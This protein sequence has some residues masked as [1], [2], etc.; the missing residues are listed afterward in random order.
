M[1]TEAS[2]LAKSFVAFAALF[3]LLLPDMSKVYA[4]ASSLPWD[5][6][7]THLIGDVSVSGGTFS[8]DTS[9]AELTGSV[10]RIVCTVSIAMTGL[11]LMFGEVGGPARTTL[12]M[13]LGTS[14][15]L[16]VGSW[17]NST[18]FQVD[19]PSAAYV[20]ISP[21][22]LDAHHTA[23][24]GTDFLSSMMRY[25]I[26]VCHSGAAALFPAAFKLLIFLA[27]LDFSW[28]AMFR[29]NEVGP[30]YLLSKAIKY[31]IFM[32]ILSNW[33]EGMALAAKI[34]TSFER[35]GQLASGSSLPLQPDAIWSNG[36][37]ILDASWQGI[38]M[39]SWS[40]IGGVLASLT[41]LVVTLAAVIFTAIALFM[42]R[43]EFWTIVTLATVLIPF[44]VW[45]KS[46]FL[47]EKATGAVLNLGIKMAV[48]SFIAAVIQPTL[49]SLAEPLKDGNTTGGL[50]D[51]AAAAEVMFGGIVLACMV[52]QLPKV[53]AGLMSGH[54]S[55]GS[56]DIFE[57]VK[58][59]VAAG[60]AAGTIGMSQVGKMEIARQMAGGS[61]AS[62]GQVLWRRAQN[63]W[64][65]TGPLAAAKRH[66]R[67]I[68]NDKADR[69]YRSGLTWGSGR[70]AQPY[71][72]ERPPYAVDQDD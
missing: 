18:F 22:T 25:Y 62:W 41:I 15:V 5:T 50:G 32:W 7:L 27:V 30:K 11:L 71:N 65:T 17:L 13:I 56:G 64:A 23:G 16:L 19:D 57:P 61:N 46:K 52:M 63:A 70:Y 37:E 67:A 3:L 21:P 40:N 10:A 24:E 58:T 69:M 48:I 6:V 2:G 38:K 12:N 4:A 1:R 49:L 36:L 35:A 45:D 8:I 44:G 42:C 43:V 55:L 66:Y 33:T 68:K 34:F 39:L 29:L 28:T 14:M 47:F 53:I 26:S 54:P 20:D 31:G 60:I 9:N 51:L 72:Y 59:A